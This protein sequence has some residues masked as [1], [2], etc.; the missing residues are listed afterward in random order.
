M[1]AT[2]EPRSLLTD[3][4]KEIVPNGEI[5]TMFNQWKKLMSERCKSEISEMDCFFAGW[6]LS[7]P[8]VRG[9]FKA[10][11]DKEIRYDERID[12]TVC[13]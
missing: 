3:R 1:K 6:I 10:V 2:I 7:N 13:K 12:A 4:L 11:R 5:V 8:T 9:Q